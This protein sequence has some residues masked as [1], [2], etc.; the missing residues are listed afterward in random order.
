MRQRRRTTLSRLIKA[1]CLSGLLLTFCPPQSR[2]EHSQG[3]I[4]CRAELSLAR[5]DELAAKLRVITGWADLG[6]ADDGSLRLGTSAP[7]GGSQTARELLSTAAK[8]E[9]VVVLED[10][11][12]R[13]DVV[14]CRVVEA[15]WKGGDMG[16]PPAYV[17]L[18]DFADFSRVM[19]DEAALAAFNVGWGVLH[20]IEHVVHDSGDPA[21]EGE[22]GDCEGLI[23]RMRRECGLAE[24]ADYFFTY[25]PGVNAGGFKTKFVRI[26]FDGQKPQS[27]KKKRFW[28]VWDADLVG[29]ADQ[30]EVIAAVR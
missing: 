26:A 24:R 1:T 22:A 27:K 28:L 8:G 13:R 25:V 16:R 6:F 11:S 5:R 20:E 12:D 15:R 7:F 2:A 3:K 4:L 21:R 23:N 14:F 17:I 18:I 10:A 30:S 19:G 9:S 29:G